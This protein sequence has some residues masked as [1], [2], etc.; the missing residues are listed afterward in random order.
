[1][2]PDTLEWQEQAQD[3]HDGNAETL[4]VI[5]SLTRWSTGLAAHS[6]ASWL[7]ISRETGMP[8]PQVLT[9]LQELSANGWTRN[10]VTTGTLH[11]GRRLTIPAPVDTGN[12]HASS[13]VGSP[14]NRG[15]GDLLESGTDTR[16]SACL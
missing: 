3:A 1:M 14:R 10:T 6:Y 11:Y 8:G 16:E 15:T 5:D 2:L 7:D 9:I 4:A 13:G 12:G